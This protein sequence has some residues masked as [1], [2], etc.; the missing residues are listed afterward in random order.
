[1]ALG[2]RTRKGLMWIAWTVLCVATAMLIGLKVGRPLYYS[3]GYQQV[4]GGDLKHS[5]MLRWPTPSAE[6]ELPGEVAGRIARLPDGRLIYGMLTEDGTSDLVTWHPE[7]PDVPPEPAYGLNTAHNELA[8][9]LAPDG[10]LYFASDRPDSI[11]GYDLFVTTLTPRGFGR[12]TPVLACNTAFDETDPAPDP[13][14]SSLVFV[15][16]DRAIDNGNDGVLWRWLLDDPLD[17]VE[18]FPELNR[19]K[20]HVIDRDPVFASDGASLWFVRKEPGRELA[21]SRSSRL[22][23]AFDTPSPLS[24]EWSVQGLRSPVPAADG[25]SVAFVQQATASPESDGQKP[26]ALWYV[27]SAEEL[28]PWWPGQHWLEWLL[29]SFALCSLLLL[30]LL[31]FGQRW[32]TLDLVAQCLL[33]SLLLHLLL[34]LW[35]MGVEIAGSLMPG[36]DDD[37]SGM[38]VSIVASTGMASAA[39]AGDA[40]DVV[41]KVERTV[42]ERS[43][44]VA[45][46]GSS[47]SR[48]ELESTNSLAVDSGTYQ[49]EPVQGEAQEQPETSLDDA[50]AQAEKRSGTD[51][52]AALEQAQLSSVEQTQLA[53]EQAAARSAS[54]NAAS[55]AQIVKV[56]T[57]GSGV[58]RAA[59]RMVELQS[60]DAA[61]AMPIHAGPATEAA[62]TAPA[63]LDAATAGTPVA[64]N[65]RA[66]AEAAPVGMTSQATI[67]NAPAAATMAEPSRGSRA[68][69][70]PE[71]VAMP[72]STVGRRSGGLVKAAAPSRSVAVAGPRN[73]ARPTMPLRGDLAASSAPQPSKTAST[74]APRAAVAAA[75]VTAPAMP[76]TSMLRAERTSRSGSR[77]LPEVR[78]LTPGSALR[79]SA[80]SIA[81]RGPNAMSVPN[82]VRHGG[83]KVAL[84][85]PGAPSRTEQPVTEHATAATA[86][87]VAKVSE[88]PTQPSVN[89]AFA[90]R[91]DA[92]RRSSRAGAFAE[93]FPVTPPLSRLLRAEP[94]R[95]S[96]PAAPQPA[97]AESAYSNRFGPAK[98]KALER[99]GGTTE[100]E[101]AV[102]DGLRY[103][104]SIQNNNGSWGDQ[105]DF[106]GKYGFVYV[107]KTALCVLAFLGAGHT[108]TS[109]TEH[110]QVVTDAVNHLIAIQDEDTG[111]FGASSCYGHGIASYALA[112]CYGLTK[113]KRF[114]D[115][116]AQP[117]EDALTWILANQGPRRDVVNRGGWGYFSP[118]LRREDSYARVSV[119]SW[120]IM[121]LESARLSG[122]ELPEDV[123]P[124]AR[125]YLELSYDRPRGWFRY[126]HQRR[127]LT[128]GWPTLPAS[129][130]AAAFCL[131]LLG[132]DP[133]HEMI[134]VAADYTVD[135]RPRR[136]RRYRDDDFVLQGQGNV[137]FW[138]Y[139][140]LCCFLKGGDAWEKW[141]ARLSTVLPAAQAKDGSFPPIDVYA[142]EAGDS[143]RDRSYT[144]AMCVLSLEVYYRYFT[145]LLLGR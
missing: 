109:G 36:N 122:V 130:P 70:T 75:A 97:V 23:D 94:R 116:L 55:D 111:A 62:P 136:Y 77:S 105:E 59:A 82:A 126:N 19:R 103:L 76:E 10:R 32:S 92:S 38:Q 8:P 2:A 3:D 87:I 11:G 71:N 112:E 47:T 29:L 142:E 145:P 99:F 132:K 115:R 133:E 69:S 120:M 64:A 72:T 25:R 137:Y 52:A 68:K 107:G 74:P 9:A 125:Q 81:M 39:A 101:R 26:A 37:D 12:I 13:S 89:H 88:L 20:H 21:V 65:R 118:G 41:A 43:F 90:P 31:Y 98:A 15:R 95:S 129:T 34:F 30:L 86:A 50:A 140:S 119:S 123:L 124:A 73:M 93:R 57:P 60:G 85:D 46:P 35:L 45:E 61:S 110:S 44:D 135:R 6:L 67:A 131:M 121:A 22:G 33:L 83:L 18:V 5:G 78:L 108:P 58:E 127:R 117:L 104:A 100:T 96:L 24:N 4:A 17:P 143:R 63:L 114:G 91:R 102:R 49:V 16:I 113:N 54:Q 106:D 138:Y 1:M 48:A 51:A 79:R 53:A 40:Y 141:N 144:T 56:A 42:R 28:V 128:S 139:G 134:E 14:G 27:A 84:R 66:D 7:R 80:P